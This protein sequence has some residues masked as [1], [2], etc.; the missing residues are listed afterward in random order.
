MLLQYVAASIQLPSVSTANINTMQYTKAHRQY[1]KPTIPSVVI[2]KVLLPQSNIMA[3]SV[4][5]HSSHF[6]DVSPGLP[7]YSNHNVTQ[8]IVYSLRS[9]SGDQLRTP[10]KICNRQHNSKFQSLIPRRQVVITL[11][12]NQQVNVVLYRIK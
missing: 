12:T 9:F 3:A 5:S 7:T 1:K 6:S 11:S 2:P 8:F 10:A 4:L